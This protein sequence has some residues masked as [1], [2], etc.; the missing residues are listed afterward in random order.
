MDTEKLLDMYRQIMTKEANLMNFGS[1]YAVMRKTDMI[2]TVKQVRAFALQSLVSRS[3]NRNYGM[4]MNDITFESDASHVNLFTKLF[5]CYLDFYYGPNFGEPDAFCARTIDGYSYREIIGAIRLHDLPENEIGDI[6]DNGS[7]DSEAKKR[8]EDRFLDKFAENYSGR[9]LLYYK[10]LLGLFDEMRDKA[11]PTGKAL[12]VADKASVILAGLTYDSAGL[13]PKKGLYDRDNTERDNKA[14]AL[15]DNVDS[16]FYRKG[17]EIWTIDF[18]HL[19]KIAELDDT[20]FFIATI[21]IYTLM[22]NGK[23]YDWRERDYLNNT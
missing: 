14:I 13:P 10:R 17:S 23:W 11:S 15:C 1:E 3:W 5:E 6:P 16:R 12:Y 19:R 9:K 21:V 8:L 4:S 7:G 20:G 2:E 18:F 22:V